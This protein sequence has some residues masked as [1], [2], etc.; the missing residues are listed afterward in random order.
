MA[1]IIDK[2]IIDF[3]PLL[4]KEEKQTLLSVIKSFMHLKSESKRI[5][6]EQYNQEIEASEKEYEE[7]SYVTHNVFKKEV[8][9]W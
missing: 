6:I 3:L 5:S 2:E 8:D 7:E 1:Q 9:Q 4:G